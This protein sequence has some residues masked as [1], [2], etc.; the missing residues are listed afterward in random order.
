MAGRILPTKADMVKYPFLPQAKE[1]VARL[2]I[3]LA[4]IVELPRIRNRAKERVTATFDLVAH[5]SQEPNKQFEVEI[6]SFPIAVL[7]V[8]GTGER[9]LAERF[10]LFEAKQSHKYLES[11]KDDIVLNVAKSFKWDIHPTSPTPYPYSMRF[12]NYLKNATR[13]RLVHEAKWKLVNRQ[14]DKGQVYVTREEVCRLLQEEIRGH[15]EERT[16]QELGKIPAVIQ[17]DIDE[18][19]AKFAKSKP[20]LEE[21]DQIII[22][23]E[24]QYPP[25]VKNLFERATKGQHL[26]HVERFTLVTYLAHQGVNV[27]AMVRL[28]SNVTDFKEDLTRY[29]VEHLAGQK[30]SRTAYTTYNCSTLR[31]HGVCTNIDDPICKRIRNPLTYHLHKRK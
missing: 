12:A 17:D 11:E 13:G 5:Y 21:F 30:G 10:A 4:Q 20:H 22:A 18:I 8:G 7:Y 14:L 31:T 3:D 1:Y 9:I 23:E 28:F 15:I 6:A 25:C 2:G 24:S 16:K 19:K 26:S 29:Q 27:D